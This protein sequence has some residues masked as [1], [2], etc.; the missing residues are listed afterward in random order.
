[1]TDNK[2]TPTEN[3]KPYSFLGRLSIVVSYS[4]L[5]A[6]CYVTFSLINRN[7]SSESHRF[8]ISLLT[9]LLLG[10]LV[11]AVIIYLSGRCSEVAYQCERAAIGANNENEPFSP[12]RK[13]G[14]MDTL[15]FMF[16]PFVAVIMFSSVF[17]FFRFIAI[18]LGYK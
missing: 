12:I 9:F 1:M 4:V 18:L 10:W 3:P 13:S 8:H 14:W 5:S 7:L 16:K 2:P 15:W 6:I 17:M 11:Y